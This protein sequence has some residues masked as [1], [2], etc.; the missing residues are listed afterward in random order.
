[1]S[2]SVLQTDAAREAGVTERSLANLHGPVVIVNF[3]ASWCGPCRVE[4]PDLN[5]VH[6]LLPDTMGGAG[7]GENRGT[8]GR[9][10]SH[11]SLS[12]MWRTCRCSTRW[13]NWRVA[14]RLPGRT[15]TREDVLT[16]NL[17]AHQ[18][19]LNF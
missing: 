15:D 8:W 7:R 13:T 1:M 6:E 11:I 9:T 14:A 16:R 12:P 18:K 17:T 19:S 4:Q 5:D 10:R 2:L 3:W